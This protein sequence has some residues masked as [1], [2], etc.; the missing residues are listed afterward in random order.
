MPAPQPHTRTRSARTASGR[1]DAT[2]SALRRSLPVLALGVAGLGLALPTAL[3]ASAAPGGPGTSTAPVASDGA[4]AKETTAIGSTPRLTTE[5]REAGVEFGNAP[6]GWRQR[7]T[8]RAELAALNQPKSPLLRY[9]ASAA[10]RSSSTSSFVPKGVLG[11]DVSSYQRDIKWSTWTKKDRD[12]AYIKATEGTS[13]KNPYFKTQY[14]GATKAGLIRGAY[15]FAS[16]SGK[17]GYL[18]ARYF[19]KNGGGWSA[20]GKTLPGVLDI[21]YNP[22]GKTCYGVSKK[23]M[24]KWISSFTKEYK[25]LTR[26]D[27]VIYTTT[28]WWTQCTGNSSAFAT[29]NPLWIARYGTTKPGTLPKGWKVATFWQ[30]GVNPID[31]DVFPSKPDRLKVLATKI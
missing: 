31:Q 23:N 13:Y 17:A 7:G 30:Y 6:M 21:E 27:A 12:F 18:Q 29:T 20:D 16:P 11:V 24:V 15:H 2:P 26:K 28:D 4:T 9:G 25:K 10:A 5:A 19:V 8:E 22:Y 1:P 3:P 14:N